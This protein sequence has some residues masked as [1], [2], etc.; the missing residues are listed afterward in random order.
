M[1]IQEMKEKKQEKGYSYAQIAEL[2]GVPLG[3]VQKIFSGETTSPRYDTLRALEQL[4]AEPL[5]VKEAVSY[6]AHTQGTYTVNDYR[7]LP[8][9]QRLELMDG[10]FYDMASPRDVHQIVSNL[11]NL[12][13]FNYIEKKNGKCIIITA[14]IRVAH[15]HAK[16]DMNIPCF[17]LRFAYFLKFLCNATPNAMEHNAG[18]I[19]G[20]MYSNSP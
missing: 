9:D 12:K 5:G 10:V 16:D 15:S 6:Q 19:R 11:I 4:F 14:P 2:S 17:S 7:A 1:T 13:I 8:E 3:T 18:A 20:N